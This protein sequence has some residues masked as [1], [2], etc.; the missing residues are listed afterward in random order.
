MWVASGYRPRPFRACHPAVSSELGD[1]VPVLGEL[2]EPTGVRIVDRL[3]RPRREADPSTAPW[4]A[5]DE[6]SPLPPGSDQRFVDALRIAVEFEL[7]IDPLH[8]VIAAGV[9]A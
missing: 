2:R 4:A 5:A 3:H 7:E 8:P 9:R 6:A 1:R